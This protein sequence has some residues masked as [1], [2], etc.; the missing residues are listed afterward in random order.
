MTRDSLGRP[1][2]RDEVSARL[3]SLEERTAALGA[4]AALTRRLHGIATD[5]P[6]GVSSAIVRFAMPSLVA[7]SVV[8]GGLFATDRVG[9][10]FEDDIASAATMDVTP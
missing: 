5:S 2:S 6:G 4:S 8:A 1:V 10:S 3:L 7:A 9:T